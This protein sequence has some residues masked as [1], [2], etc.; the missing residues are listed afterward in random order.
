MIVSSQWITKMLIRLRGCAG[1]SA[2]LLFTCG[3][4][5]VFSLM[6]WL[7]W[8][9]TVKQYDLYS[10]FIF[11]LVLM[12][13]VTSE[14]NMGLVKWICVFEHS[15]MTNFNCACPAI[16]RGQGSGFLSEGSS[17]LLVWASSEGSGETGR[18]RRLAWTFAARIGDKYQI[19]LTRPT[20]SYCFSVYVQTLNRKQSHLTLALIPVECF[21]VIASEDEEMPSVEG[22]KFPPIH[23]IYEDT[24]DVWVNVSSVWFRFPGNKIL[25][26][27][28]R[29]G[30]TIL[31][32]KEWKFPPIHDI[33]LMT[34]IWVIVGLFVEWLSL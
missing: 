28:S 7:K 31:F 12:P 34:D 23:V 17:S 5:Q 22:R 3:I 32:I 9:D 10:S 33:W 24:S 18:M 1:W 21:I 27:L 16:Q 19:R 15:V 8:E 26:I 2:S 11:T 30:Y 13:P 14:N 4:R 20:W 6:T 25:L 29:L